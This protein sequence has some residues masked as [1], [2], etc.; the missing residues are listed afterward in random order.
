MT[1]GETFDPRGIFRGIYIPDSI[2]ALPC[3][4]V[5]MGAKVCYAKL[6]YWSEDGVADVNAEHIASGIGVT[7]RQVRDYIRE[8]VGFGLV[9]K[10]QNGGRQSNWY[11]F[12]WTEDLEKSLRR[13][14]SPA[15]LDRNTSSARNDCSDRNTSSALDRNTSSG[16]DSVLNLKDLEVSLEVTTPHS[17][18]PPP[19]AVTFEEFLK[20]WRWRGRFPAPNSKDR[21][22]AE[23]KWRKVT[24][25]DPD[26]ER[27]MRSYRASSFGSE[28]K[29]PVLPFASNPKAWLPDNDDAP[30]PAPHP[31][32]TVAVVPAPPAPIGVRI[33]V[34]LGK[35]GLPEPVLTWNR[36]TGDS[37]TANLL[38]PEDLKA[39]DG[40]WQDAEFRDNFPFISEK[41][42]A[43]R[44]ASQE[45][46][47]LTFMWLFTVK[48]GSRNP[49][50]FKIL[51]TEYDFLAHK[52]KPKPEPAYQDPYDS[53]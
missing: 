32:T 41:A 53:L 1:V 30:A 37:L 25:S 31:R 23:E 43:I 4:R 46:L 33:T 50:W 7:D 19:E 11:E 22:I 15:A 45:N 18:N 5:S 26:L 16:Q 24:I 51:R 47:W 40:A 20:A 44:N 2:A 3:S 49:G 12:L 38:T 21:R 35:G 36:T 17:D 28:K 52:N 13:G 14:A 42:A 48:K 10:I 9:R 29:Y 27:A 34:P 6:C 39:L 8:L